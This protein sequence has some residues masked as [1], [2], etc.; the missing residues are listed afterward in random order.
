MVWLCEQASLSPVTGRYSNVLEVLQPTERT[1]PG[2]A[3]SAR[4]GFM[5]KMRL[6]TMYSS[7]PADFMPLV[8]AVT[9]NSTIASW[10]RGGA[11]SGS[12]RRRRTRT[13]DPARAALG[14]QCFHRGFPGPLLP[15]RRTP[16]PL[17]R[18]APEPTRRIR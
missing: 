17:G 7:Q 3:A 18:P 4:P 12:L 9:T 15:P 16:S 13:A 14:R 6:A 11:D 8:L 2:E 10:L 5:V 1:H